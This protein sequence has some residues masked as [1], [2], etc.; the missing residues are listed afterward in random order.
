MRDLGRGLPAPERQESRERLSIRDPLV[1]SAVAAINFEGF[2]VEETAAWGNHLQADVRRW[3]LQHEPWDRG[4]ISKADAGRI[5]ARAFASSVR[6]TQDT[7]VA[8]DRR[9]GAQ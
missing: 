4:Q 2:N 9:G 5:F 8:R 6:S 7:N 3:M 1:K